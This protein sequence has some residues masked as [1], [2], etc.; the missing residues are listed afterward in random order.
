MESNLGRHGFFWLTG[1]NL[2][3]METKAGTWRQEWMESLGGKGPLACSACFLGAPR[4]TRTAK[5]LPTVGWAHPNESLTE[6]TPYRVSSRPV[7]E[8]NPQLLSMSSSQTTLARIKSTK[9]TG[10]VGGVGKLGSSARYPLRL[11]QLSME[12][13]KGHI[14]H[15]P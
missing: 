10:V 7:L 3:P 4:I 14:E 5:A 12:G 11:P 6:K 1:Y 9:P 15:S 2:S 13:Y 8:G